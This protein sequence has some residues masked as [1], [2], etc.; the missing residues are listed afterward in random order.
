M[1]L[2]PDGQT[3]AEIPIKCSVR[4]IFTNHTAHQAPNYT[5]VKIS[6]SLL[7]ELLKRLKE[8]KGGQEKT[9]GFQSENKGVFPL[10]WC[11]FIACHHGD[12]GGKKAPMNEQNGMCP[13]QLRKGVG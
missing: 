12:C 10:S 5:Y 9:G 3:R 8:I 13:S 1:S 11:H 6:P 2:N 4:A 7:I